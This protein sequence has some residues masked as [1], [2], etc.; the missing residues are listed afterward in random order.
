MRESGGMYLRECLLENVG[1][2]EFVDLSLPFNED[3]APKPV[4]L[5]GQNRSG[6]SILMSHVIDALIEFVKS[7]YQNILV[8]QGSLQ[9]SFF[10]VV[11][12]TTQR[13]GAAYKIALLRF[14]NGEGTHCYVDNS[15]SLD[16][17]DYVEKMGDRFLLVS[18]WQVEGNHKA[19]PIPDDYS[20]RIRLHH[21]GVAFVTA[22]V[23]A[24]YAVSSPLAN[25]NSST[26]RMLAARVQFCY[27]EAL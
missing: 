13:V 2:I 14:S 9:N 8:G 20:H 10:K 22:V 3:G 27:F 4:V 15:G 16:P 23:V 17:A 6:K 12:G 7:A 5:V 18:S 26:R 24:F 1:P 25:Y 19:A 21:R 11:G